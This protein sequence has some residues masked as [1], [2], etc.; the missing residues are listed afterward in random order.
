VIQTKAY[1]RVD[2][3]IRITIRNTKKARV[4]IAHNLTEIRTRHH[5]NTSVVYCPTQPTLRLNKLGGAVKEKKSLYNALKYYKIRLN[6]MN[7]IQPH[8]TKRTP[9]LYYDKP[10]KPFMEIRLFF[11]ITRDTQTGCA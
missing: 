11:L 6:K 2:L 5:P 8:L 10:L 7:N 1:L 4:V 9:R 3:G